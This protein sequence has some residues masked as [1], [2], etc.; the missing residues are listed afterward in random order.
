[1]ASP[2]S[3]PATYEERRPFLQQRDELVAQLR[4]LDK[5]RDALRARIADASLLCAELPWG[6][7]GDEERKAEWRAAQLKKVENRAARRAWERTWARVV[8]P[9]EWD[10]DL[11]KHWAE[12]CQTFDLGDGYTG[13]ICRNMD[14]GWNA[15]I[16][17]PAGHHLWG[18]SY[19]SVGCGFTYSAIYHDNG[20]WMFGYCH[21]AEGGDTV[22]GRHYRFYSESAHWNGEDLVGRRFDLRTMQVVPFLTAEA[23]KKELLDV[24]KRLM[25][26]VERA[27]LVARE[28]AE[29]AAEKAR[30]QAECEA[31]LERLRQEEAAQAQAECKARSWAQVA[32]SKAAVKT[33]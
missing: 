21:D 7:H 19:E 26:A 30:K 29:E 4:Q 20:G 32:G 28:A 8:P 22:P 31:A 5:E 24:K 27:A 6:L 3:F 16:V 18:K 11:D 33:V 10:A 14:Y 12:Q 9:G 13:Q 15:Y 23:V 25:P 2:A 1:M 17:V